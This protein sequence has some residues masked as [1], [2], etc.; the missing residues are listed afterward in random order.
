MLDPHC[1]KPP[2]FQSALFICVQDPPI[3]D[4]KFQFQSGVSLGSLASAIDARL[5]GKPLTKATL[6]GAEATPPRHHFEETI[7][8][9][10]D[11]NSPTASCTRPYTFTIS[12][13]DTP[14]A[15]HEG[16]PSTHR[17]A[18]E[19]YWQSPGNNFASLLDNLEEKLADKN[20]FVVKGTSDSE[21]HT[22]TVGKVMGKPFEMRFESNCSECN[23][24]DHKW[25]SAKHVTVTY[26]LSM[27]GSPATAEEESMHK[28]EHQPDQPNPPSGTE[29]GSVPA[30]FAHTDSQA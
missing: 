6:V 12:F 15:V 10:G 19:A 20:S 28:G 25:S 4:T 26:K 30:G 16:V 8:G 11:L 7:P 3:M 21:I 9:V 1:L 24:Y 29:V 13:C 5:S 18:D 22:W 14:D 27:D 23:G 2:Y 17:P